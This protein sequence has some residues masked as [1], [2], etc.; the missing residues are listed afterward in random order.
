MNVFS[1]SS[2][3]FSTFFLCCFFPCCFLSFLFSFFVFRLLY[4]R[5][6]T[7]SVFVR[8]THLFILRVVATVSFSVHFFFYYFVLL[9]LFTSRF[10]FFYSSFF[11]T[12]FCPQLPVLLTCSVRFICCRLD[13]AGLFFHTKQTKL[14]VSMSSHLPIYSC[15]HSL[16]LVPRTPVFPSRNRRT[17]L[18]FLCFTLPMI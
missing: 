13:L 9:F 2:P 3:P 10:F 14:V 12:Y 7:S 16:Y 8:S 6:R 18:L 1:V 17:N 4:G 5:Y 11:S 15:F